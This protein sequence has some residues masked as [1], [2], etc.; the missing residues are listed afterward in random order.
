[1]NLSAVQV[2]E[3]LA[4]CRGSAAATSAAVHQP[5]RGR[6]AGEGATACLRRLR[7]AEPEDVRSWF[8]LEWLAGASDNESK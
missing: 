1:M 8:L 4:L 7:C 5:R 2:G 3:C 6:E